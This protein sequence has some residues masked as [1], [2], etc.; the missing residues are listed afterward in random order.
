MGEKNGAGTLGAN[1]WIFLSEMRIVAGDPGQ[2]AGITGA[3]FT[4]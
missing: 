1:Q 4:G 3:R 2:F